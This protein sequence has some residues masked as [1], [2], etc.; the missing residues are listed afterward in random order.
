MGGERSFPDLG[1]TVH[2]AGPSP[3]RS[4]GQQKYSSSPVAVHE[5][6]GALWLK[7]P[8]DEEGTG[9]LQRLY[10]PATTCLKGRIAPPR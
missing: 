8:A 6:A 2:E 9:I 3:H 10:L 7:A 5:K 4:K 1:D